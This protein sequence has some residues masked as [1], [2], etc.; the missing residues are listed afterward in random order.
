MIYLDNA[1]TTFP[2]PEAVYTAME[3]A[4]RTLAFNA[5]RGSYTAANQ[6]AELIEE[7]RQTLLQLFHGEGM[8]D[9]VFTPSVT[10]A[11]NQVL[12]GL[13]VTEQTV[14]YISPYEHN[15]VARTVYA[16]SERY[17][18]QIEL[19]PLTQD[20]QMDLDQAV[21]LFE[22]KPPSIVVVNVLSNVTGYVLPVQA[23]FSMAKM[24]G[25]LTIADAAQAAGLIPLDMETLNADILCFAGH[26]TLYGPF[27]VGGF[28]MKRGVMLQKVFT[29]GTGSN[30]L[31]LDMPES[32]P[33]RFEASSPNIVAICG[34]L[35]SLKELD[36]KEHYERVRALTVYLLEQIKDVSRIQVLGETQQALG[37]V[38]FVVEGY[39]SDE[40]GVILNDE[41]D[42]AV[43][44]GYHCCPYIHDFLK[45][46]DYNGTVRVGLGMFNTKE[47]IARLIEALESL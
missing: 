14:I 17:G 28:A 30:S 9:I 12:H 19:L 18:A 21:Y 39:Q 24:H 38:S 35:A 37:I 8:A 6:A 2:K 29:G 23:L 7:T 45:D 47:E 46:K 40:V 32:I 5:G 41:Y 15:A 25:A 27:G 34:L 11:L 33:A 42:I 3:Y 31:K 4:N 36:I 16:L 26:K 13:E 44:T 20:L 10:H 22:I 1:A 43:R